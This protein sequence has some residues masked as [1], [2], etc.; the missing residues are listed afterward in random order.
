MPYLLKILY[1]S[2]SS[3]VM[4]RAVA[5]RNAVLTYLGGFQSNEIQY[6]FAIMFGQLLDYIKINKFST[7][8]DQLCESITVNYDPSNTLSPKKLKRLVYFL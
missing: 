6:F 7:N 5:R 4:V 1:G 2:L 3:Y 8:L